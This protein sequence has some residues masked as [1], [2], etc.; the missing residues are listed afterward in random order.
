MVGLATGYRLRSYKLGSKTRGPDTITFALLSKS[1][2]STGRRRTMYLH[3]LP[4]A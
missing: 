4:W 3:D 1:A 2:G